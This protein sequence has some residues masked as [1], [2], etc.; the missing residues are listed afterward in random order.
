MLLLYSYI[1]YYISVDLVNI[2]IVP[3]VV[4]NVDTPYVPSFIFTFYK[5]YKYIIYII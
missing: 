3:T 2:N 1:P 4:R 5:L